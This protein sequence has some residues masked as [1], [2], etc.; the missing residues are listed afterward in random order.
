MLTNSC[1]MQGDLL[2]TASDVSTGVAE[3]ALARVDESL[4]MGGRDAVK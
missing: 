3:Y 4:E 2:L 1:S